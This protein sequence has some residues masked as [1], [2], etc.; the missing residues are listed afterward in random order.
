[1][2]IFDDIQIVSVAPLMSSSDSASHRFLDRSR[3]APKFSRNLPTQYTLPATGTDPFCRGR[4]KAVR[5][6]STDSTSGF[7]TADGSF[8][9]VF[10]V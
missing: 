1:M 7:F 4:K 10:L 9:C 2:I 8:V 5:R 6:I 3:G